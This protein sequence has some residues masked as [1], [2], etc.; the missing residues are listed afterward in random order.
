MAVNRDDNDY[1]PRSTLINLAAIM[2]FASLLQAV[3]A[4]AFVNH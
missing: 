3:V 1:C 4:R 2:T